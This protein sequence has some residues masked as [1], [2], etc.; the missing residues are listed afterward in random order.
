[1]RSPGS[2][3]RANDEIDV[4]TR[5]LP[6]RLAPW[7][8]AMVL[9]GLC[10]AASHGLVLC[11]GEEGHADVEHSLAGCC[12]L[13]SAAT[14]DTGL[15]VEALGG[16][17]CGD[18][19]DVE[20]DSSAWPSR[21]R[22]LAPPAALHARVAPVDAPPGPCPRPVPTGGSAAAPSRVLALLATVVLLT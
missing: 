10:S 3:A 1:M 6:H 5:P 9:A 15:R 21:N 14:G 19:V 2:T 22:A 20:I 8:A 4:M 11:V 7:L 13:P 16:S 12:A 17:R 18:C